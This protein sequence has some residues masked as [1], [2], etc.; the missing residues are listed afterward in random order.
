VIPD[1]EHGVT[2]LQ[3]G[4]INRSEETAGPT[5]DFHP[6]W[7]YTNGGQQPF[8]QSES[9][10][11]AEGPGGVNSTSA[12]TSPTNYGPNPTPAQATLIQFIDVPEEEIT[13][14]RVNA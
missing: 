7:K 14:Q 13:I 12:S 8:Q 6:N 3:H 10:W 2:S 4:V 9:S 11:S 1:H 5:G